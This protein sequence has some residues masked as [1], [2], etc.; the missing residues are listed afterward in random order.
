MGLLA[1]RAELDWFASAPL[2]R[3]AAIARRLATRRANQQARQQ[4]IL[5]RIQQVQNGLNHVQ[6][7]NSGIQNQPGDLE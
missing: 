6:R 3:E 4:A 2:R 7:A 5:A 1:D